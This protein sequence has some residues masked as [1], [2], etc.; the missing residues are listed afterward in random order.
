MVPRERCA[1][2]QQQITRLETAVGHAF[3]DASD[4]SEARQL[5][6]QGIGLARSSATVQTEPVIEPAPVLISFPE[7]HKE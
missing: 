6:R 2:I 3:M 5:D 4:L 7:S 1:A